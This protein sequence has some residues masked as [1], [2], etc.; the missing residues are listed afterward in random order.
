MAAAG[1]GLLAS[2]QPAAQS[3]ASAHRVASVVERSG[4]DMVFLLESGAT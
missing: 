4:A 2:E 3:A 1:A